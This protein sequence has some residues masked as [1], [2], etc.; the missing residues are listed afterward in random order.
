VAFV[1]MNSVR[2]SQA[3]L[4]AIVLEVQRLGL[5]ALRTQPGFRSARLL[6]AED[7]TEAAL[8]I[9]WESREH[10]IAF[11]QTDTGRGLVQSAAD[12]HPQI[13]FYEVLAA[14]EPGTP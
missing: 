9:E 5:D 7:Q 14:L 4:P 2:A 12:L 13:A 1:V 3:E 11:R 8:I 6:V 10:F